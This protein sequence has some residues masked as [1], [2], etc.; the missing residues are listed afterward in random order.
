MLFVPLPVC[1]VTVFPLPS[2]NAPKTYLW[3]EAST[4]VQPLRLTAF[5]VVLRIYTY[6]AFRLVF[7]RLSTP[8]L[9]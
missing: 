6:S 8:G 9:S 4:S 7:D 5:E 2:E 1:T 3:F